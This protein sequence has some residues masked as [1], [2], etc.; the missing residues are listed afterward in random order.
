MQMPLESLKDVA[1]ADQSFHQPGSYML[2]Q[3]SN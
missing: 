1:M 3:G 2:I